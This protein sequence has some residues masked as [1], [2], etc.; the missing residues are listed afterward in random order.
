MPIAQA[1]LGGLDPI[2]MHYS[3][4]DTNTMAIMYGNT[5]TYPSLTALGIPSY[6]IE[7]VITAHHSILPDASYPANTLSL[8]NASGI[9]KD[10]NK[11]ILTTTSTQDFL[12]WYTQLNIFC[13]RYGIGLTPFQAIVKDMKELGLCLPG[14]GHKRYADAAIQLWYI[15][16]DCECTNSIIKTIID[17]TMEERNGFKLIWKIAVH[18]ADILG[19]NAVRATQ[20]TYDPDTETIFDL[21]VKLKHLRDIIRLQSQEQS[22][23]QITKQFINNIIT[24]P[25]YSRLQ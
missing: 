7:N 23:L 24:D 4:P 22:P 14:L 17:Q 10:K 8:V 5:L 3:S 19:T 15:I 6:T 20:P 25:K 12:N 11:P 1:W 18:G 9:R 16:T 21:V 2:G 13:A